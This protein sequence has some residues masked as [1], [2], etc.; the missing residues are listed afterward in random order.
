M[1]HNRTVTRLVRIILAAVVASVALTAGTQAQPPRFVLTK[2]VAYEGD[3]SAANVGETVTIT[4]TFENNWTQPLKVVVVDPNPDSSVFEMIPESVTGGAT[5]VPSSSGVAERVEWSGNLAVGLLRTVTFQMRVIGGAGRRVTNNASLDP[6]DDPGSLPDARAEADIY[7][8]PAAPILA[9]IDNNDGDGSYTVSWSEVTGATAYLLEE[10]D[11]VT[12]DTPDQVYAGAG[13]EYVVSNQPRGVW[14]YRVRAVNA[15]TVSVWSNVQSTQVILDTPELFQITN[16][17]G[18]ASYLVDWSDVVDATA[19]TLQ[20][21]D[22][23]AFTS[24]EDVYAGPASQYQVTAQPGGLWYYRVRA[25]NASASSPWSTVQSVR[26]GPMIRAA[27]LP[28]VARVWPP[29]PDTPVLQPIQNGGGVGSYSVHW[30]TAARAKTYVLQEAKSSNFEDAAEIYRG[31]GTRFDVQGRGASRLYYRVKATNPSGESD[32]SN[33]QQVDVLWEAEPNDIPPGQAKGPLVSGLTY[34]GT[35]PNNRDEQDYYYFDLPA[36][37]SVRLT[38]QNIPVGH[39]YDLVLW[40]LDFDRMGYSG[41][42]GNENESINIRD[43][44]PAGRYLI[45]VYHRSKVG[46]SLQPYHL[47]AIYE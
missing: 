1:V 17:N 2:T 39:N 29:R 8:R 14:Y 45:Q 15:Y 23:S 28:M 21:D 7:I 43:G 37:R 40:D 24:P 11:N 22:N 3:E 32:W 13:S 25:E 34:F 12:F 20:E 9:P 36:R 30:S 10:D 44:I 19:Y 31:E 18:A 5:Y 16:P 33:R 26:V 4:L 6:R 38:L 42:L 27:Y 41:Q 46:G 35:F 47:V